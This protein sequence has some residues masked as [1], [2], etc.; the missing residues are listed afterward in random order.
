M[1]RIVLNISGD[2]AMEQNVVISYRLIIYRI[3]FTGCVRS[4]NKLDKENTRLALS[5]L[6]HL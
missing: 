5:I 6:S 3:K 2:L 1:T 4:I